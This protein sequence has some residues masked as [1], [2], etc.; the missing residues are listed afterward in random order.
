[1]VDPA[2]PL[3]F[4]GDIHSTDD[5]VSVLAARRLLAKKG[6]SPLG[7]VELVTAR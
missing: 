2:T 7:R 3:I 1:M 5:C 6:Y 4:F